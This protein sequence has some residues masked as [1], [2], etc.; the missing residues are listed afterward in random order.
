ML[1]ALT[2]LVWLFRDR[3]QWLVSAFYIQLLSLIGSILA[4]LSGEEMEAQSEG[5]PI[6]DELVHTH[7]EAALFAT[8]AVG[9]SALVLLVTLVVHRSK[10]EHPDTPLG[11][12]LLATI[13]VL[14]A[15][16]LIA[17]TAHVGGTM[18]WGTVR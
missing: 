3:I 16:I 9:L 15:A 12:R 7:E 13:F 2:T 17:L 10:T 8:L 4:Y 1:V 5:V 14:L 6:V 11:M 18:V